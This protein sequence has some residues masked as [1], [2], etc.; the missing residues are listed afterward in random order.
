MSFAS[1]MLLILC[2]EVTALDSYVPTASHN[3]LGKEC[4]LEKPDAKRMVAS[5]PG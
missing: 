5:D 4:L 2:D 1:D 3:F